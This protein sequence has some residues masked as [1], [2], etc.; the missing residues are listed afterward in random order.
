MKSVYMTLTKKIIWSERY[1]SY[2]EPDSWYTDEMNL[3]PG[4]SQLDETIH[5]EMYCET[6]YDPDEEDYII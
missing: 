3:Q 2:F 4:E 6:G 5:F 1:K